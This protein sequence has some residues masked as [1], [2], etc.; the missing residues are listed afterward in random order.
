MSLMIRMGQV[1]NA[2]TE[3]E[4]RKWN[5]GNRSTKVRKKAAYRRLVHKCAL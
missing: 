4:V 2:E 5:Y 1:E 3:T